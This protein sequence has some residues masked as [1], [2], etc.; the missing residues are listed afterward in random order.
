MTRFQRF[1]CPTHELRT[2]MIEDCRANSGLSLVAAGPLADRPIP[3]PYA[4]FH[5]SLTKSNL[6][7]NL[8]PR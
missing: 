3:P 2:P 8:V 7:R 6:R 4:G 5:K 1:R